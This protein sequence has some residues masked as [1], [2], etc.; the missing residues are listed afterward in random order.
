MGLRVSTTTLISSSARV[1]AR[2]VRIRK[3]VAMVAAETVEEH[4]L[5]SDMHAKARRSFQLLRIRQG[6]VLEPPAHTIR[7][8]YLRKL[9]H[10]Y[11]TSSMSC[12]NRSS[13]RTL[14]RSG[15]FCQSG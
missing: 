3:V 10:L 1:A 6:E 11:L 2:E 14:S 7:S 4:R 15:S 12:W 13:P 8:L 5:C 9:S